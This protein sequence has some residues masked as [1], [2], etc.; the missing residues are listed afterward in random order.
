M[1]PKKPLSIRLDL[2]RE[3]CDYVA[4]RA[5]EYGSTSKYVGE[6]IRKDRELGEE[7]ALERELIAGLRSGPMRSFE[8]DFFDALRA[9][10]R[11]ASAPARADGRRVSKGARRRK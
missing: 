11:A 8:P 5:V 6:L 7:A 3:Q 1:K 10:I 4:E 9:R 2:S